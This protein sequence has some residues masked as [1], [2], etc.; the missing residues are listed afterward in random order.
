MHA[1]TIFA[2]WDEIPDDADDT[3]LLAGG[4]RSYSCVCG[5][6]LPTRMAAELHA[7]E[8][9]QCSTCLGSA[10]EEVVPGFTRRCTSCTGTGRRR[11]QLIW[12]MAYAQAEV[13]I[14]VEVVRGVISRFT[15][16]FSLSQAADAVRGTLG[17]RPGRMPVGPR[18]RDVLRELEG[19]G[20]IAL[21]S[22]PDELLRGASIVLYR[23]PTWQRTIPA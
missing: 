18:V 4:Y 20:E 22:A 23:D 17:L 8:T 9:D 14:T 13:T 12:E 5:T 6:P 11:M 19:T 1:H 7:V 16:P 3:A 15:G 2:E 10:V 21:I